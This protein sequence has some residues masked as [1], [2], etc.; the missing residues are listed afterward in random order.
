MSQRR[1]CI[2]SKTIRRDGVRILCKPCGTSPLPEPHVYYIF[3]A[4]RDFRR[5]ATLC[6]DQRCRMHVPLEELLEIFVPGTSSFRITGASLT[7]G[8]VLCAAAIGMLLFFSAL[9]STG[10]G[11]YNPMEAKQKDL[12][13]IKRTRKGKFVSV[14]QEEHEQWK[15]PAV[16]TCARRNN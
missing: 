9:S 11:R 4:T 14:W 2:K 6:L 16:R 8:R 13:A 1:V 12:N 5:G 7:E 10:S 3:I 15:Y